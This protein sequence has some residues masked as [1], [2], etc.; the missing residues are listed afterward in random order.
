ME[1]YSIMSYGIASAISSHSSRISLFREHLCSPVGLALESNGNGDWLVTFL[2]QAWKSFR[3][4]EFPH[5]QS[6]CGHIQI[7]HLQVVWHSKS[8]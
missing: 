1:A 8:P 7:L 5:T 4:K 3:R 6:P 2:L